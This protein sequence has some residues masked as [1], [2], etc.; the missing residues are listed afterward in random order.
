MTSEYLLDKLYKINSIL[1]GTSF[2]DKGLNLLKRE[3]LKTSS[4]EREAG[5]MMDWKG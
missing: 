2:N 1:R 5:L 4:S 3:K